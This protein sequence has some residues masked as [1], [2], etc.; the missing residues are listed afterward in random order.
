MSDEKE[1]DVSFDENVE[2]VF[3]KRM[4]QKLDQAFDEQIAESNAS[5]DIKYASGSLLGCTNTPDD[6]WVDRQLRQQA[7]EAAL[8]TDNPSRDELVKTA[9]A[10]YA[11]L[12]GDAK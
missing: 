5:N 9:E 7:L 2:R 1:Q 10:Y 3:D 4:R 11:F 12:K 6:G 8:R